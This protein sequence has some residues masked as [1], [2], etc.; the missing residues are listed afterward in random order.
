MTPGFEETFALAVRE[1]RPVELEYRYRAG[2]SS[3]ERARRVSTF[4]GHWCAAAIDGTLTA[5][6]GIF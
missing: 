2:S 5:K 1:R 6:P 3:S 4:F